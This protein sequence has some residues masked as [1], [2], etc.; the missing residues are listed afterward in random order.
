MARIL[1]NYALLF[2]GAPFPLALTN[3]HSKVRSHYTHILRYADKHD[4]DIGRIATFLLE[5]IL[6]TLDNVRIL[7]SLT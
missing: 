6:R 1:V 7:R 4:G 5:C 3:G 2:K